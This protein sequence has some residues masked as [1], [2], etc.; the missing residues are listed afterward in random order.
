M[1]ILVHV[2]ATRRAADGD[3]ASALDLLVDFTYFA[4]QM[5]DREFHAEMAWGLHHIIST[6]ERLR[7]VAYVDSRDDE[8]LESDAIHEV[9]E[10]LSSDRRAYLGLDRLTFPRADML[11]ARQVIEMT[12]ERNGG[13]RPQ[14]FSS[15][16]SQ[17]TTSDL[18]LRLFSEHAKW[19]DAAVIQM[20]WNG[21]NERVARIEGDWRVRWDLDPY[22]PVNQ[23]PFAYREINPIE[24]ARCAAVFESVEDMSDLFELRMLAN[25]EAVGTRHALGAIG[26]HIETSRFA[27]QI[28]SIRPAWIAEIEADPFNADRER[29]RKPPLFYF[30][31]I[32]DT[33]DR[34]PSAQ[35]VGPHQ[36]NI[37]MADGPNIRVLLR[38]DTFVM[39]SV[40]PDS[41]KNWADEVQNSATAPSGRDYLIWPPV[42][43]LQRTN[44]V[45][46]GQL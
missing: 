29:G 16:L 3:P 11:G 21:V 24:R 14:I 44:L 43:S 39:Y 4:R 28:Q 13:A 22:D 42:M 36:L 23:Q 45:Q 35:Q 38:D 37:I 17:L 25:V 26:Y 18:P 31:P 46:D 30:V 10:R 2:E 8:A 7:D 6:L 34:F 41:A 5:A 15:T 33:A 19:R 20:P 12:Y 32:R 40:G 9:I 1:A 27:P